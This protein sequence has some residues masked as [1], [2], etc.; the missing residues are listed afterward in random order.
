MDT[1]EKPIDMDAPMTADELAIWQAYWQAAEVRRHYRLDHDG[2]ITQEDLANYTGYKRSTIE[3][4]E[5]KALKKIKLALT[6]Y[7]ED[8][9]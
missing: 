2:P 3:M 8:E 4:I 5:T 7:L 9:I 6:N 1:D